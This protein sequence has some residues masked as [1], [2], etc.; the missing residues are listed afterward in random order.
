MRGGRRPSSE[1]ASGWIIAHS[2]GEEAP[3]RVTLRARALL[4]LVRDV[5]VAALVANQ[6]LIIE[7]V[8]ERHLEPQEV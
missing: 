3:G 7:A 1:V 2:K 6:A 5:V 8:E 4:E